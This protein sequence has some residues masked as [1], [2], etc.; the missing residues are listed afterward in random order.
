M[1]F[2][3][4]NL[5]ES[6]GLENANLQSTEGVS[7]EQGVVAVDESDEIDELQAM[8]NAAD[9]SPETAD[10]QAMQNTADDSSETAAAQAMQKIADSATV[11]KIATTTEKKLKSP[12]FKQHGRLKHVAKGSDTFVK[13]S[14]GPAI[15]AIQQALKKLY[16]E[17]EFI[18]YGIYGDVT[19]KYIEKFQREEGLRPDSRLGKNTL[20]ALDEYCFPK[21]VVK[22]KKGS[23]ERVEGFD[24][25]EELNSSAKI[26]ATAADMDIA[27]G[28]KKIKHQDKSKDK[29]I[30]HEQKI[31]GVRVYS[32]PIRSSKLKFTLTY[33]TDVTLVGVYKEGD[34]WS[35]IQAQDGKEGWI[36]SSYVTTGTTDIARANLPQADLTMIQP[37]QNLG[38]LVQEKYG[39][40]F[41]KEQDARLIIHAIA[42]L[43]EGR[44]AMYYK[45]EEQELSWWESFLLNST[46]EEARTI[47]QNIGVRSELNLL[48]PKESLILQMKEAQM[49][50]SGSIT[51]K[52]KGAID[53]MKMLGGYHIGLLD[54][55]GD[56]LVN[57]L[58]SFPDLLKMFWD[59]LKALLQGQLMTQLMQMLSSVWE[60]MKNLPQ[61]VDK[62]WENLKAKPPF[63]QGKEI[64]NIIG[65]IAFEVV[66]AILTAG[67]ATAIKATGIGARIIKTSSKVKGMLSGVKGTIAKASKE[68]LNDISDVLLPLPNAVTTNGQLIKVSHHDINPSV[69]KMEMKKGDG[70]TSGW[71]G[72]GK[73]KK[74]EEEPTKNTK[75]LL[76]ND[77]QKK[78]PKNKWEDFKKDFGADET[79]LAK[80]NKQPE[81]V[82]AW[83]YVVKR[84]LYRKNIPFLM[85][86]LRL[87]KSSLKGKDLDE[88]ILALKNPIN[89]TNK[90]VLKSVVS[91][92][93]DVEYLV[94]NF[95]KINGF[96]KVIT[97]LKNPNFFA[98]DGISH[99][100]TKLKKLDAKDVASLE[101]KIVDADN[102][103][104]IC[105]NCRFDIELVN[106]KK[107]ELKSY[108]ESTIQKIS[109]SEQFKKQF[110][111]Y[112]S[113]ADSIDNLEYIFN[114][115]KTKD[116]VLI[117]NNFKKIFEENKFQLYN[118]IMIANPMIF[119]SIGIAN[120]MGFIKAVDNLNHDLYKFIK[121]L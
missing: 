49:V 94:N 79:A 111:S 33:N 11:K 65:Q 42:I 32:A 17:A 14:H 39:N 59:M 121:I 64:G 48:L 61:T 37:S 91:H 98:Q 53:F 56:G 107:L 54:G 28:R 47:Y 109:N 6:G 72:D 83:E 62:W 82:D 81:L 67:A 18:K 13:G 52:Y 21:V 55:L 86:I 45:E 7:S 119:S 43:N 3:N 80:F 19:I 26:S 5:E 16:P 92:L 116:L 46:E 44:A 70:H 12:L 78:V 88:I 35:L 114:G 50:S 71:G 41:V 85:K 74:K 117:K 120:K 63:E 75:E 89:T 68:L 102:L 84:L 60:F 22:D 96:D 73:K 1:E 115:T 2:E 105:L 66:L 34:S 100:L 58:Q 77:L 69:S 97:A 8:Q 93:D 10:A 112:L 23:I 76:L 118:D 108:K 87:K 4:A 38:E 101:G 113:D 99:F 31:T 104:G 57:T 51:E 30:Y 90:T 20:L 106:G 15:L 29:G 95:E 9:D 40:S 24:V 27:Q 110:K 103:T 25:V 36:N